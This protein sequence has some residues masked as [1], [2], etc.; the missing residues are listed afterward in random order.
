MKALVLAAALSAT[1]PGPAP[2]RRVRIAD[3]DRRTQAERK[4]FTEAELSEMFGDMEPTP[5]EPA[6]ALA[7]P[8]RE[9]ID[10]EPPL[11]RRLTDTEDERPDTPIAASSIA[12]SSLAA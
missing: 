10:W 5:D 7:L 9:F 1:G 4:R 6:P 8:E 12:H 11:D 3:G 2:A